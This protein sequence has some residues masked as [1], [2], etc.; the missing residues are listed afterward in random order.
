M[1]KRNEIDFLG[2]TMKDL[3]TKFRRSSKTIYRWIQKRSFPKPNHLFGSSYW[4]IVQVNG[5]IEMH[6]QIDSVT[7]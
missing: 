7:P 6:Y 2:Y 4:D 3:E 5:W 1:Q